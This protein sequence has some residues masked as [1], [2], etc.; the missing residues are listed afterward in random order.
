MEIN[1]YWWSI[2]WNSWRK[3]AFNQ[4]DFFS[5]YQAHIRQKKLKHQPINDWYRWIK[6]QTSSSSSFSLLIMDH[7]TLEK[8]S[9]QTHTKL[10]VKNS[11]YTKKTG[12]KFLLIGYSVIS[13]SKWKKNNK[14]SHFLIFLCSNILN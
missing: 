3:S 1:F 4:E 2:E 10:S 6:H 11:I 5:S 8:I 9:A 14:N 12:Q 7:Q 13:N